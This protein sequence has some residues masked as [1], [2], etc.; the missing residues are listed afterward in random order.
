MTRPVIGDA[1]TARPDEA[2]R[3]TATETATDT[4]PS[5]GAAVG[6]GLVVEVR[7]GRYAILRELGAGRMGTV[8]AA[9]D[10]DLDREVA[11]KVVQPQYGGRDG[12][13]R[14]LREA[15]AMARLAHP[16]VVPVHDVGMMR[17]GV[18]IAMELVDGRNARDWLAEV[19]PTWR[20][21]LA[22][23]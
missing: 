23:L 12:Q 6:A 15:Q 13:A 4:V 20:S 8:Y 16:G 18:F 22:V 14:L 1:D 3:E 19:R 21:A 17:D 2:D 9:R 10:P 5:G 11:I 7:V